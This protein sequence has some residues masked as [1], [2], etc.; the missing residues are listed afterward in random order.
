MIAPLNRYQ[1]RHPAGAQA[2]LPLP[3]PHM[4]FGTT[5]LSKPLPRFT[6]FFTRPKSPDLRTGMKCRESIPEV[7]QRDFAFKTASWEK[8]W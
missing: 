8:T 5:N 2:P 7:S 4:L 6:V 1:L 3:L